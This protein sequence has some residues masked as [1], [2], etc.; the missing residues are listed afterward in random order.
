[1][2]KFD[3]KETKK[4]KFDISESEARRI[5]MNAPSE[6]ERRNDDKKYQVGVYFPADIFRDLEEVCKHYG[7]SRSAFIKT[8]VVERLAFLGIRK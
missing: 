5:L 1:M 2:S 4:S 8:A 6:R 3:R 7:V